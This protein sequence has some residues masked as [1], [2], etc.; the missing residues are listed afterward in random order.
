MLSGGQAEGQDAPAAGALERGLRDL[1]AAGGAR[2]QRL[3]FVLGLDWPPSKALD[4]GLELGGN[5]IDVLGSDENARPVVGLALETRL[6]ALT[7]A[8]SHDV[9]HVLWEERDVVANSDQKSCRSQVIAQLDEP[10]RQLV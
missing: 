2:C 9:G 10:L 7:D 4:L 6:G 5:L 1:E 3:G 8:G